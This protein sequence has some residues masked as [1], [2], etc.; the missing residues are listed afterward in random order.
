MCAFLLERNA[1]PNIPSNIGLTPL[2]KAVAY[3][4]H[5][6]IRLLFSNNA[7]YT[8]KMRDR[9]TIAHIAARFS[10]P[11]TLNMLTAAHLKNVDINAEN[12][13]GET[14]RLVFEKCQGHSRELIEAFNAFE[15]S[16]GTERKDS[17]NAE[18]QSDW[19]DVESSAC[20]FVSATEYLGN[21]SV[22]R[23]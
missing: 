10:Q 8:L 23:K 15:E 9:S 14:A 12:D 18:E 13:E 11:L 5:E 4:K 7:N 21:D 6:I 17:G 20:S 16:L 19:S 22:Q 3:N 2:L 1:N